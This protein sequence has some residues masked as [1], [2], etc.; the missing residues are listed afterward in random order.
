MSN[1]FRIQYFMLIAYEIHFDNYQMYKYY[2]R[3]SLRIK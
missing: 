3:I 1:E 2:L